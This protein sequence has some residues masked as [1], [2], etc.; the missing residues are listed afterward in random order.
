MSKQFTKVWGK[1]LENLYTPSDSNI[2]FL[3]K[4][5][6]LEIGKLALQNGRWVFSYT[7]EFKQQDELQPLIGF[8]QVEKVYESPELYPFFVQRI[9]GLKQPKVQQIIEK[10]NIDASNEVALLKRF[11][12]VSI[13]NPFRLEAIG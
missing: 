10:E 3:L 1:G 6:N 7:D 12:E 9:P 11:G 2:T 13:A 5:K 8:P 4:Y